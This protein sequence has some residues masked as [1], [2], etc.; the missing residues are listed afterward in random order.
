LQS[1]GV[2]MALAFVVS[3]AG[4]YPI[5]ALLRRRKLGQTISDD[6]P[7]SHKPKA[8]TPTMGGLIILLGLAAATIYKAFVDGISVETRA[9]IWLVAT[10]AALGF[11]DDYLTVHPI[12]GIRGISSKPK[13]AI[14]I[15]L[16]VAFVYVVHTLKPNATLSLSGWTF[17]AGTLYAVLAVVFVGG[18]ANFVNITDGL[19][20]LV[21]GLTVLL[22]SFYCLAVPYDSPHFLM[23]ALAASTLAFLWYNANPARVFMGDTGSL[24]IGAAIA[25]IAVA[26]NQEMFVIVAGLV[27]VLDGFSTMIQ[28]AVFKST[29]IATGTGRRVFKKSPIHHHFELSGWAEPTVVTRF[30]II[31]AVAGAAAVLG[32]Y[33][34]LW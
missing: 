32:V 10:Y 3:L 9:V 25:G 33:S 8:G 15:I 7:E 2:A 11:V 26:E 28:W 24:A 13:A 12:R 14:Q 16:A 34:G 23:M 5:I 17:A 27:F 20:G 30:W 22:A 31:G 6:G 21:S 4:G 18:M 19:D 29:R 1:D